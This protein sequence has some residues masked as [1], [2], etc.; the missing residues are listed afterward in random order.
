MM[1]LA[2]LLLGCGGDG[3]D[4]PEPAMKAPDPCGGRCSEVELCTTDG[5]E[6]LCA[7]ICANQLRCWTGCCLPLAD[8]EY[9]VCRPAR[10]CFA[11]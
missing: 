9:N 8:T 5:D 2:V 6:P 11:D 3:T 10:A 7:R 1:L 4:S